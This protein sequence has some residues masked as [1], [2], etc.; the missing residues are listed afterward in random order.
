MEKW[1]LLYNGTLEE[2]VQKISIETDADG[3]HFNVEEII[4]VA[5]VIASETSTNM[6]IKVNDVDSIQFGNV[7]TN[8]NKFVKIHAMLV[9]GKFMDIGSFVGNS[10]YSLTNLSTYGTNGFKGANIGSKINKIVIGKN[11]DKAVLKSGSEYA[12]YGR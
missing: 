10:L 6:N 1:K 2:D 8:T 12:V 3:N 11:A 5:S 4:I 9:A 7:I